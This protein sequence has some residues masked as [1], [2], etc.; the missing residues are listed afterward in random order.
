[1]GLYY[2]NLA[3]RDLAVYTSTNIYDCL[4]ELTQM[5]H[6][7]KLSTITK[8]RK[9][10][11]KHFAIGVALLIFYVIYY[12]LFEPK[13]LGHDIRF[14]IYIVTL[15]TISGILALAV[16]RRHFLIH[17]FSENKG[18]TLWIFMIVSYL[19]QGILFSYLS[20][21]QVAKISWDVL[22]SATAKENVKEPIT[23]EIT[24]FRSYKHANQIEFVFNDKSEMLNVPYQLIKDHL[25]KNP[26]DY[27]IEITVQKA[28]WNFYLVD[29]WSIKKKP[30]N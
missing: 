12:A 16:Y 25:G 14:V 26:N 23:C 7:Q 29:S 22:N 11:K 21:G 30:K 1:M 24:A 20:F 3:Q 17:N 28:L 6:R 4:K 19:A 5:N 13:M 2:A 8:E 9:V 10:K 18:A 15:P 27:S